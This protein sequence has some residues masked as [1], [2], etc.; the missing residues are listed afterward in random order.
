MVELHALQREADFGVN[1]K[2]RR[3]SSPADQ[4]SRPRIARPTAGLIA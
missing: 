3:D 1:T 2:A 4:E